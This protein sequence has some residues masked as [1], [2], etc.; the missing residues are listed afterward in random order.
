MRKINKWRI[1]INSHPS[2]I[3]LTCFVPTGVVELWVISYSAWTM[4]DSDSGVCL[5]CTQAEH[6]DTRRTGHK[7]GH[8]HT[9]STVKLTSRHNRVSNPP[10]LNM[11]LSG[12]WVETAALGTQWKNLFA[13]RLLLL[14]CSLPQYKSETS[15]TGPWIERH[16]LQTI[17]IQMCPLYLVTSHYQVRTVN[18]WAL[19]CRV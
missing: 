9:L 18:N 12:L 17:T 13:L 14:C 15:Q 3:L 16:R 1:H 2:V 5:W 19:N 6:S 8:T 4:T 7:S 10:N 11:Y